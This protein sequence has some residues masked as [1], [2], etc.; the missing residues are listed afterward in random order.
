MFENIIIKIKLWIQ[1]VNHGIFCDV[2]FE[3]VNYCEQTEKGT[4][5]AVRCPKCKS[6]FFILNKKK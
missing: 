6:E 5:G 3:L 2:P 1:R 4:V